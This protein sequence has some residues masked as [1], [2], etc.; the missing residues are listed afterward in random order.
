MLTGVLTRQSNQG[1][2]VFS[3]KRRH[4]RLCCPPLRIP[5]YAS[6]GRR[7]AKRRRLPKIFDLKRED[8]FV[9]KVKERSNTAVLQVMRQ[10]KRENIPFQE[11][12]YPDC[13]VYTILYY[14]KI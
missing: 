5:R 7:A 12:L 1:T 4:Y 13:F 11:L 8:F 6:V 9:L 3:A 2:M 10:T 14:H